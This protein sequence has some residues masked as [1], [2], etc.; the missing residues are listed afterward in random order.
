LTT[1]SATFKFI[2][3]GV[4]LR[5]CGAG[6]DQPRFF[7]KT[8]KTY[9]DVPGFQEA[10][11]QAEEKLVAS[12]IAPFTSASI[13]RLGGLEV[14]HLTL[15]MLADLEM[16]GNRIVTG[17]ES[18]DFE[19]EYRACIFRQSV[20]YPNHYKKFYRRYKK[21]ALNIIT[22]YKEYLDQVTKIETENRSSKPCSKKQAHKNKASFYGYY[23]SMLASEYG[24]TMETIMNTP[25][26][27]LNQFLNVIKESKDEDFT[28]SARHP[29]VVNW[30]IQ[31]FRKAKNNG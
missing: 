22:Q 28:P 25:M 18:E 19:A 15:K 31:E 23:V 17:G 21:D 13:F 6:F 29:D 5:L 26:A 3:V 16:S 24:W 12:M 11:Q 20:Y 2:S 8:M 7:L 27:S 9:K 14:Y 4:V 1:V 10:W 30:A